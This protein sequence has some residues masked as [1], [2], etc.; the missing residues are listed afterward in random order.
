MAS[1]FADEYRKDALLMREIVIPYH[2]RFNERSVK[3]KEL[4][5]EDAVA[6]CYNT[7]LLVEET[8]ALHGKLKR[9]NNPGEDYTDGSDCKTASIYWVNGENSTLRWHITGVNNKEGT[10][11]VVMYNFFLDK[12]AYFLVPMR[13]KEHFN[14]YT[15]GNGKI[16]GPYGMF[17]DIYKDLNYFRVK[18]FSSICKKDR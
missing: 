9:S 11:R 16:Q 7:E 2:P 5:I 6:G 1:K 14:Y 17:N 10:L 13:L 12:L 3:Q 8:I 18:D 4:A 15:K